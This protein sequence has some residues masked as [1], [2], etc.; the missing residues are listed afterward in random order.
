MRSTIMAFD[1]RRQ[2][3]VL[4]DLPEVKLSWPV[5][6]Q[7]AARAFPFGVMNITELVLAYAPVPAGQR[8][9]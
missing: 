4:R 5:G 2:L 6:G 1:A 9:R 3:P 8:I 7:P